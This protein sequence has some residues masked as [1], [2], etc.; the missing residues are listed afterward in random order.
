MAAANGDHAG[1]E[2]A[3]IR[4]FDE[5]NQPIMILRMLARHFHRLHLAKGAMT[6]GASIDDAMR[7]LRPP[8]IFK[9]APAFKN[10][11]GSWDLNRIAMALDLLTQAEADCKITGNPPETITS[12]TLMRI[13]QAARVRRR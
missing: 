6:K 9:Q 4:C 12:R 5:G 7:K 3:L 10:Q 8:V 2:T 13:A 1:L 11:L